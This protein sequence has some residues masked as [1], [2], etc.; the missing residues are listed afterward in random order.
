MHL[1]SSWTTPHPRETPDITPCFDCK[2]CSG[3]AGKCHPFATRL[4]CLTPG[5]DTTPDIVPRAYPMIWMLIASRPPCN[6]F[7]LPEHWQLPTNPD[8]YRGR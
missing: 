4:T 8:A 7:N 5:F 2:I 1:S 6:W 3:G